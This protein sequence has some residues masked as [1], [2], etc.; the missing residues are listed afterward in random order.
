MGG[1]RAY[2]GR[3]GKDRNLGETRNS[4]ASAKWAFAAHNKFLSMAGFHWR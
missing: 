2:K 4:T 1:E 3:L